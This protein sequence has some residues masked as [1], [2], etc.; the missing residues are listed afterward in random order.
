[1]EI[2]TCSQR[3][4]DI[5]VVTLKEGGIE[6]AVVSRIEVAVVSR[7]EEGVA[8]E[9]MDS[10]IEIVVVEE[11]QMEEDIK[12]GVVAELILADIE[13]EDNVE[14]DNDHTQQSINS[15]IYP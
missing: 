3:G 13:A 7:I 14:G 1:M 8:K 6:E 4:A 11:G 9:V 10:K 12:G 2:K 5:V 15:L